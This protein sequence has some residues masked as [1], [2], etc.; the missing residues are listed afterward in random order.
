MYLCAHPRVSQ[1]CPLGMQYESPYINAVSVF[2][3]NSPPP[4]T[5]KIPSF[6]FFILDPGNR[7]AIHLLSLLT[8]IFSQS[9]QLNFVL[10]AQDREIPTT[11]FP[12]ITLDHE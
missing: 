3:Q 9:L 2:P 6:A 7:P 8:L 4:T 5:E 11:P 12:Y 1:L 10:S